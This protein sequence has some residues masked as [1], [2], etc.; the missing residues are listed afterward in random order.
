MPKE[1]P[2]DEDDANIFHQAMRGVVPLKKTAQTIKKPK[3]KPI[4]KQKIR[5]D[6]EVIESLRSATFTPGNTDTGEELLFLRPGIQK[7][8]LRKLRKRQ[9][10]IDAELD[11]HGLT[12][13][14][15]KYTLT[16]FIKD[17][18]SRHCLCVRIIHGKGLGSGT[19]GPVLKPM[20]NDWLRQLDAVLAF[21]PALG[22]DGGAGA[23]Y[24]LLKI[25]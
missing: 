22:N 20:L 2:F 15:T 24:L 1:P 25:K 7:S 12:V 16:Q 19:Q 14:Q 23:I 6:L 4:P 9:Y 11:L 5:D 3:P 21:C 8:V 18:Q 10:R 17:C 13:R